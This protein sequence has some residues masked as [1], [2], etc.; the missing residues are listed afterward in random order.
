MTRLA[1]FALLAAPLAKPRASFE[2]A[3]DD[4]VRAYEKEI[5]HAAGGKPIGRGFDEIVEQAVEGEVNSFRAG[6]YRGFTYGVSR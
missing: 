1:L 4:D 5:R 6:W 2:D 3:A